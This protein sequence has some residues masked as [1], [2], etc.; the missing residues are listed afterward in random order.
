MRRGPY[1][2]PSRSCGKARKVRARDKS[3]CAA[4]PC[5]RS[6]SL[7][8]TGRRRCVADLAYVGVAVART[9]QLR[10]PAIHGPLQGRPSL[11]SAL[12]AASLWWLIGGGCFVGAVPAVERPQ[13]PALEHQLRRARMAQRP[14]PHRRT[15]RSVPLFLPV[16]WFALSLWCPI[17]SS[18]SSAVYHAIGTACNGCSY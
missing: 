2:H 7:N 8:I 1:P 9:A 10:S 14:L 6:R 16:T 18:T 3:R 11:C 5:S 13:R 12:L 17:S 4:P 15:P